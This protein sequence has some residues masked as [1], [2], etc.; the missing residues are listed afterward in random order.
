LPLG[1][2]GTLHFALYADGSGTA[3]FHIYSSSGDSPF[4]ETVRVDGE[5]WEPHTLPVSGIGE[6][7]F[8][9]EAPPA[10]RVGWGEMVIDSDEPA[11]DAAARQPEL[12]SYLHLGDIRS[13]AQLV[14]GWYAME[15]GAWRWMSN[16]AE[17]T[18]RPLSVAAQQFELQLFFPPDFMD[19]AGT[20]VT[21]SVRLNGKPFTRA[22]YYAPGGQTL[23][24]PVPPELLTQ[25][26]TRVTIRVSPSIRP[27]AKDLRTLGAVVQ[28]L[29]FV[30]A[31]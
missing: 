18:L 13:R 20:P 11:P 2:R 10:M 17:A 3:G 28:G 19:R 31:Q 30:P 22:F 5:L 21:V 4:S 8:A 7:V 26:V 15:D 29:G 14:S 25:P 6:A 23:S 9:I 1:S 24:A 27:T 16:Q 12:L